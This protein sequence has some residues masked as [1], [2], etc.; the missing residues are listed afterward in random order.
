MSERLAFV[1]NRSGNQEIWV[2]RRDGSQAAQLTSLRAQNTGSPRWSPDGRWIA[3]DSCE[4]G[5]SAIYV[6]ASG[7]GVPRVLTADPSR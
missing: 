2:S 7:G 6:V 4:L 3:F 1:S 5:N